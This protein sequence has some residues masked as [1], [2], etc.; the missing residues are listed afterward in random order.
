MDEALIFSAWGFGVFDID[1]RVS[2][3]SKIAKFL[4]E[5]ILDHR[6]V[7]LFNSMKCTFICQ[8]IAY[9]PTRDQRGAVFNFGTDRVRVLEK[10]SGSGSGTDR[11]RVLALHFYQSG[12]IGY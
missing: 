5:F 10:T 3:G 8:L 2:I 6:T 7:G 4:P 12:I 1:Y 9:L 11:V